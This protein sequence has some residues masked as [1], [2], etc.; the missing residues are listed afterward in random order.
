M[1]RM[2]DIDD[3]LPQMRTYA[4]SVPDPL[5]FVYLRNAARD[6]CVRTHIW[7]DSDTF[8]VTM[9]DGE[10][11]SAMQDAEIVRIQ[12]ARLDG[13]DLEPVTTDWLDDN[14]PDWQDADT[15]ENAAKYIAHLYENTVAIVPRQS[16]TLTCRLVLKPSQDALT[17]PAVLFSEHGEHIARGAAG[18]LMLTPGTEFTNPDMAAAFIGAFDR[19]VE[20]AKLRVARSKV[21]GRL[22]TKGS[23]F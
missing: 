13:V 19:H 5:A 2:R 21:G 14:K 12:H 17:L 16:G 6:F 22:R 8:P 23:Y 1:M 3:F 10:G 15:E 18:L 4:P 7:K 20:S 9:P 11:L